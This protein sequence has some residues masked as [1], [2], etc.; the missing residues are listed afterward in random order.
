MA[1]RGEAAEP[2]SEPAGAKPPRGG[3]YRPLFLA[4]RSL[5]ETLLDI[6]KLRG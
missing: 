6:G 2:R 4:I 3:D 5:E 1:I